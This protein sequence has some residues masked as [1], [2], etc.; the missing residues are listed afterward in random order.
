MKLHVAG[1]KRQTSALL[2][3]IARV[4]RKVD[5][6]LFELAGIR[7]DEGEVWRRHDVERDV[8]ANEPTQQLADTGDQLVQIDP[9]GPQH[10]L[11]AECEQ[12]SGQARGA[13]GRFDD[14]VHIAPA[15][16]FRRE[17]VCGELGVAEDGGQKIVEIVGDAAGEV[18][19]GV[20]F[21]RL[22]ELGFEDSACGV[23]SG[24]GGQLD[25]AVLYRM[26]EEQL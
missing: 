9:C 8:F 26:H 11:A 7:Q 22:A 18:A 25:L 23:V 16:V 2:H 10:L 21:L 5:D 24:D 14:F 12:L 17:A 6:D 20:H 19:D 1:F 4:D 3:G 15:P 13:L